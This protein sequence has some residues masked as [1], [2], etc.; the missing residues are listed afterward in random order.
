MVKRADDWFAF[1]RQLDLGIEKM[2]EIILVTG[3]DR[4]VSWTNVT[5]SGDQDDAQASFGVKHF[6]GDDPGNSI[7]FS[8][9]PVEGAVL[10]HGPEGTVRLAPG[11][12]LARAHVSKTALVIRIF[13][14]IKLYSSE[15]FVLLGPPRCRCLL[16]L[17]SR[18]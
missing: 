11:V 7:Q 4:T 8:R 3:C 15:G 12:F 5:F 14:K 16:Y 10:N 6:H 9:E 1:A 2:E 18:L 13:P 17:Q